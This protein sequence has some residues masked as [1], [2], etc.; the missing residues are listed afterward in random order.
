MMTKSRRKFDAAF[1]VKVALEASRENATMAEPEA[2]HGS[3]F[4]LEAAADREHGEAERPAASH[5][6]T[7]KRGMTSLSRQIGQLTVERGVYM[8]AAMSMPLLSRRPCFARHRAV[9][10]IALT[11]TPR[12]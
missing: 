11:A 3:D 1:K 2:C 4:R 12:L 6:R 5:I 9:G 10:S 8:S 7:E